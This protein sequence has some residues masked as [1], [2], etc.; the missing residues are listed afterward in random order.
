MEIERAIADGVTKA[1]D[2]AIERA[3]DL[4]EPRAYSIVEV[5][6][7]LGVSDQTVYR[8]ITAGHLRVVPHLK[9]AR[10]AASTLLDFL[11]Q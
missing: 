1:F 3:A 2:Q 5:A 10:I 11:G 7:R 6:E 8:L 9:P 4:V